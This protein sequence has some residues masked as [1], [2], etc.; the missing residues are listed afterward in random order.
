VSKPSK[1]P[2]KKSL[3]VPEHVDAC[4]SVRGG[5]ASCGETLALQS[6]PSWTQATEAPC[7]SGL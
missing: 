1:A 6:P 3:F 2:P 5:L 4:R 7:S